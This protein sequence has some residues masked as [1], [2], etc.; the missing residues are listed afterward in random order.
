[1]LVDIDGERARERATE[2]TNTL[3]VRAESAVADIT[4]AD[5]VRRAA[6]DVERRIGPI[7]ILINNAAHDPKVGGDDSLTRLEHLPLQRWSRDF[8]VGVTGA[9]LCCQTIG[10]RM[11]QRGKGTIVNI[12]SDLGIIAPDQ[13]LYERAGVPRDQQPVKPVT[14]SVVKHALI[15]LTRYLAT[16][17]ADRGVR[18]NA[19][20]PG[21]VLAG[22]D[23][24]FL[25]R[26]NSRI[27]MG[28][29]AEPDEYQGAIAF[30]CSDASSYVT[31]TVLVADGGRT[32]W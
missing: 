2:L 12:A 28:R 15:G 21:G 3:G 1:V 22:Q 9:F 6:D 30:L 27:P 19:L 5:A 16:Y 29:L 24:E 31:G 10:T 8:D 4:D 32:V 23:G 18:V 20:A 26:V 11:A 14:Y 13:R 25:T 17:W 7:S